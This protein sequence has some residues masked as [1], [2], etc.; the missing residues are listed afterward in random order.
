MV[1]KGRV[2]GSG[3]EATIML[4]E[5]TVGGKKTKVVVKDRIPKGYRHPQL[6]AELRTARTRRE[7]KIIGK[8]PVPGPKLY[9]TDKSTKIEMEYLD[10]VQ[11]KRLLEKDLKLAKEIGELLA[12][13]HDANIIHGDLT[14]SNM[15][16]RER[17][18]HFIDFGLSFTSHDEEDK[19]VDI[20]LFKQALESK[21][22]TVFDT[23][24]KEF[25]KGYTKSK[26]SEKV[27]ERLKQVERRGRNKAKY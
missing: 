15:I 5:K 10:G 21:H 26:N 1:S 12:K 18:L 4:T 23:A 25:L 17:K 7:A 3:A 27:L 20:H 16:V 19:A 13:L 14:T 24:Y 2:I 9:D 8:L 6:D 22:Y 11:V